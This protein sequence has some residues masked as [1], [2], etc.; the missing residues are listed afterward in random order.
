MTDASQHLPDPEEQARLRDE[1][2][3]RLRATRQL[4][5]SEA[6]YVAYHLAMQ[7]GE[8]TGPRVLAVMGMHPA[9][10]ADLAVVDK[11]FMGAVF[12]DKDLWEFVRF[13]PEGTHARPARVWRLVQ[14]P[15]ERATSA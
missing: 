7:D 1:A 14:S 10:A 3:A 15:L 2:L 12:Q 9:I 4:L 6:K 8:V 5:I 13:L 11:R